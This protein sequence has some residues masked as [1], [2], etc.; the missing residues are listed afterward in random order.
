MIIE[1]EAYYKEF[2]RLASSYDIKI[3]NPAYLTAVYHH[4]IFLYE[5]KMQT[6]KAIEYLKQNRKLIYERLDE[7]YKS[8]MDSYPLIDMISDTLAKWIIYQRDFDHS[9][10]GKNSSL[11]DEEVILSMVNNTRDVDL[12]V[13]AG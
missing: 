10:F 5:I 12:H 3:I 11:E 6:H 13:N 2:F 1:T 4:A 8:Y 9:K 7:V